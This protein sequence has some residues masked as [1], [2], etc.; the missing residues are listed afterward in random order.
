MLVL[1]G[2]GLEICNTK[3]VKGTRADLE[4]SVTK[5]GE[6]N[7][8]RQNHGLEISPGTYLI[9]EMLFTENLVS[10]KFWLFPQNKYVT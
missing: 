2:Q 9:S 10:P 1:L 6:E 7:S 8:Q 3:T 4:L 5:A